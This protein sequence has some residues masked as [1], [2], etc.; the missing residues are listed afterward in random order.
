MSEAPVWSGVAA[1]GGYSPQTA[2]LRHQLR[3]HVYRIA[4]PL[5]IASDLAIVAGSFLFFY[6]ARF[7][8]HWLQPAPAPALR[9][10]L[11]GSVL[12]AIAWTACMALLGLYKEK[13]GASKFDDA[14][15][16]A[17]GVT[18]GGL[19]TL[20]LSFFYRSFSYS[21]LVFLYAFLAAIVLLGAWHACLR[22]LQE[23]GM[24]RGWGTL[25][26]L[27]LGCNGLS[28]MVASR[29]Q[30][31]P[32][33]GLTLKGVVAMPGESDHSQPV[34]VLGDDTDL[35]RLLEA[36]EV[37]DVI[38]AWPAGHPQQVFGMIQAVSLMRPVAVQVAPGMLE[39]MT[40]HF[41]ISS[42][43][44]LPMLAIREVALRKWHN[45]AIKRAVDVG[46]SGLA[47]VALLPVFGAIAAAV[48]LS[49]PGPIFYAQER[50][51]RD[52]RTFTI[53]KFRSMPVAAEPDGPVWA[54]RGDDRATPLGALLRRYSLDELPQ[55]WNV[56]RG[57]MTLVGPRPERPYFADQFRERVPKYMDRHLVRSGLTGWA[58]V[59]GLRGD[60]AIE[61]RTR[62][63][64]YYVENWS[65]LLDL[66]IML[67]TLLEIFKRPGY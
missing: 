58:Q 23:W 9:P 63:D 66:R 15:L 32:R 49:S 26:T 22:L 31:N 44:G 54:Q 2:S 62:Y 33:L 65:L 10:Y 56:L 38:V 43:D 6:F 27:I 50:L 48:K 34:A 53:F 3:R 36:H 24:R 55:L 25:N 37:D 42:L 19:C 21:R 59:N 35:P 14:M 40:A 12:V 47:L 30:D 41:A 5:V 45:R 4:L 13:R 20:S 61:E 16:M 39:W 52:G 51:G 1:G 64:I 46:L 60:V 18:L 67:K 11:Q 28:A 17:A 7:R 57:D 29:I 8:W